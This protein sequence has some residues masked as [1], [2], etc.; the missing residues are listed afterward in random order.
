MNS[1]IYI[2]SLFLIL[3]ESCGQE[4]KQEQIIINSISDTDDNSTS[5]DV[6]LLE[7]TGKIE[8]NQIKSQLEAKYESIDN[9]PCPKSYKRADLDTN[10]FGYYLRTFPLK[11]EN[12][13][14]HLFDESEK[15]S[16]EVHFAILKIDVGTRDLQQCADAVM[17]LRG[18]YLF[19]RKRFNDIH[20]N[21]LSDGK[22]RY[23]IEFAGSNRTHD[24]FRKYMNYIFS[25]ANTSSL[26]DELESV[27]IEDMQIGDVF[28]QS[29][30]PYGHAITVMDMAKNHEG[31]KIFMLSQSYMPAQE[32]HILKNL[33]NESLSPWYPL[34]FGES[35]VTPEWT[36][37]AKDLKRFTD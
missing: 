17:R 19:E 10:S 16:Q 13:I 33:N 29:G 30:N 24:K 11:T 23:Y 32:I 36:F 22:P 31:Q 12:N 15:W 28:I 26:K 4:L 9:I 25:Y 37:Y 8:E 14:V 34:N 35:L 1:P 27:N 5:N 18:E 3:F 6:E 21:F 2:L 20:F 7:S